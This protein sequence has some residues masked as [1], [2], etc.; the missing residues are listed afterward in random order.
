M[1]MKKFISIFAITLLFAAAGCNSV[2]EIP[3]DLSYTQLIQ[4]GQ[5]SIEFANYKAAEAYYQTAIQ[6][7][8][9]NINSYIESTYELGHLY[10]T[11]KKYDKAVAKFTELQMIYEDSEAGSL[12]ASFKKLTAINMERIPEKYR[13]AVAPET[14]E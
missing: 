3:T 9:L 12:P 10:L 14:E 6:R 4:M 2:P 11:C 7:Y 13:S 1:T 5:D 8:G